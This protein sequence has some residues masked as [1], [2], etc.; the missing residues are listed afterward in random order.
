MHFEY[1]DRI[2]QKAGISMD[3][4]EYHGKICACLCFDTLEAETLLADAF[5]ADISP[6]SSETMKLKNILLDLITETLEKLNDAEMTFYP[7]LSPDS[8]SLTNRT[9]SLSSWVWGLY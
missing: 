9:L 8:K 7:L 4:S 1:I 3:V 5:N 2:R 6:L